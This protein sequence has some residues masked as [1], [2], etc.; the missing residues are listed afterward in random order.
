MP[1]VRVSDHKIVKIGNQKFR[2]AT[3]LQVIDGKNVYYDVRQP[4]QDTGN[5]YKNVERLAE[6]FAAA[7]EQIVPQL[8][9]EPK[10]RK[11]RK[12]KSPSLELKPP[13]GG[14]LDI[15]PLY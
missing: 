13:V 12:K 9:P 8:K 4:M 2:Q 14:D 1:E 11:P 10:P 3:V 7:V 5:P 15:D 6:Q